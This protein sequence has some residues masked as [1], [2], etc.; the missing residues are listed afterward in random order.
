MLNS[1]PTVSIIIPF[2][3]RE[4]LT[5]QAIESV[6]NQTFQDFEIILVDDG[7]TEPMEK[8][9]SI[10]NS[11]ISLLHQ[12]NKGPAA[13]R[14]LG[15]RSAKGTYIAFL[16]SDDNFLPEKLAKQ[17]HVLQQNPQV[18]LSHTSYQNISEKGDLLTVNHAGYFSGAVFP[19]I[20]SGCPIAPST[21][22]INRIVIDQNIWYEENYRISEDIIFFAKIA[23]HSEIIGI[24]D[25]LTLFRVTPNTH[26]TR[27]DAQIKGSLNIIHFLQNNKL[28]LSKTQENQVLS[29]LYA[30][31]AK[32]YDTLHKP[33]HSFQNRVSS[34]SH[35]TSKKEYIKQQIMQALLPVRRCRRILLDIFWQKIYP[36]LSKIKRR[37]FRLI[38]TNAKGK[39]DNE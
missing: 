22:L 28:G 26:G 18:W 35:S 11:K 10:N 2:F 29:D 31:I 23:V 33:F 8:I 32:N 25:P 16:D 13:A 19:K 1:T 27:P 17:V 21:V 9:K 36:K 39:K 30:Y 15:M 5:L 14:N 3:N 4:D 24:D 6:L 38:F 34:Y 37:V 7:S 20:L 12:S